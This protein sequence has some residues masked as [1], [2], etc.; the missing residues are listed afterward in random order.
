MAIEVA[1]K[2]SS[3]RTLVI[4][5]VRTRKSWETTAKRQGIEE[6]YQISS[7]K[8]GLEA[9]DR[10]FSGKP[11]FYVIGREYFHLS[12]TSKI[13]EDGEFTRKARWDYG[14]LKNLDMVI[15][16]ESHGAQNR[17]SN[18]AKALRRIPKTAFKLAMS[19]T[20]AGNR[21]D[22]LWFPC[23]WLWP[24]HVVN[25]ETGV[26]YVDHRYHHWVVQW[27]H[28]I[29]DFIMVQ[30]R[31]KEVVKEIR[32]KVPG[33]F[34]ASLPCYVYYEAPKVPVHSRNVSVPLSKKQE[35]QY[36]QMEDHYMV[37]LDQNPTVADLTIVQKA[38]LRQIG[39]GEIAFTHDEGED[40]E[41]GFAD[42]CVSAKADACVKISETHHPDEQI[43]YWTSSKKF[44]HVLAKRIPHT[45]VWSG[46]VSQ[47]KRD[48]LMDKF[49]NRKIKN[50]VVSIAS[51]AEGVD[52]LQLVSNT[53]VWLDRTFNGVLNEQAEGRVN[54]QG[55]TKDHIIRYNLLSP[56][57]D[58]EKYLDKL[59]G[60]RLKMRSSLGAG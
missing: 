17:S 15:L 54:R 7:S 4:V 1:R 32:E 53:E 23:H 6:V 22:G 28:K 48:T 31:P 18:M 30:G 2:I 33:S 14:K 58:D 27:A 36:R 49:I 51:M 55:Q 21:F 47:A 13:N 11:G 40:E 37:W 44:A 10:L 60:Q 5:P 12:G 34:V 16:D 20:P 3:H 19:A 26:P 45:E 42:D 38:R 9:S 57:T 8:K 56:F 46:D 39:L 52:G 24:K 25:P 50:L 29:T 35:D 41:I 43:I 59:I